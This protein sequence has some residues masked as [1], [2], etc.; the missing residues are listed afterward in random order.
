MKKTIVS[1]VV[2]LIMVLM[3]SGCTDKN[4]PDQAVIAVN[5]LVVSDD[6]NYETTR[7]VSI[8]LEVRT[9]SDE[10]VGNITFE[11]YNGD[12]DENGQPASDGESSGSVTDH[13]KAHDA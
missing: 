8:D 2:I 11:I 9:N 12:P 6:F 5:D 10:P 1:L 4:K 7:N 3:I 13:R